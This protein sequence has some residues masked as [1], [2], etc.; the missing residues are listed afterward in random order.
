MMIV[1]GGYFYVT[2]FNNYLFWRADDLPFISNEP[3][4]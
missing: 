2:L 4:S 1:N 3:L